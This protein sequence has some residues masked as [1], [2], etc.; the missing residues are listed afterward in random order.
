MNNSLI[1][2]ESVKLEIETPTDNQ[3]EFRK[4]AT[5]FSDIIEALEHIQSSN[6]WK[7]LENTVFL[8]EVENLKNQ[9]AKEDNQISMY[10][11]QGKIAQAQKYDLGKLITEKRNQLTNIKKQIHD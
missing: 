5:E 8:N 7:T 4:K 9:L 3:P 6:Y 10:R 1:A 11:L 2:G